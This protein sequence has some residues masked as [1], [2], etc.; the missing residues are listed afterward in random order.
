MLTTEQL[1]VLDEDSLEFGRFYATV[2]LW[3]EIVAEAEEERPA[4][5]ALSMMS[6]EPVVKPLILKQ[7]GGVIQLLW[8]SGHKM[9]ASCNTQDW[10]S[11][12]RAIQ[13]KSEEEDQDE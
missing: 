3:A 10:W 9:Y 6:E 13:Q 7:D 5:D 12:V 4:K 8:P 1:F 2:Y 11:V